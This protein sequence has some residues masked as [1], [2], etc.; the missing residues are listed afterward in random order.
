MSGIKWFGESEP[1]PDGLEILLRCDW[2]KGKIPVSKRGVE[3]IFGPDSRRLAWLMGFSE[4][5]PARLVD[6]DDYEE[7]LTWGKPS[8]T[9]CAYCDCRI[10]V[11][12]RYTYRPSGEDCRSLQRHYFCRVCWPKFIEDQGEYG[13]QNRKQA[14]TMVREMYARLH[15]VTPEGKIVDTPIEDIWKIAGGK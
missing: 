3:T 6:L 2:R 15:Q 4:K 5:L 11:M 1:E 7:G 13:Q 12:T 9:R 10:K 14:K 8:R